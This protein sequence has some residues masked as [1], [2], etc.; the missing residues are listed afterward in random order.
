MYNTFVYRWLGLIIIVIEKFL[1][2]NLLSLMLFVFER[3]YL[4]LFNHIIYPEIGS[5]DK[6]IEMINII[7]LPII[8]PIAPV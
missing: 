7:I 3:N 4:C 2:V 5:A 6:I 1:E 8:P